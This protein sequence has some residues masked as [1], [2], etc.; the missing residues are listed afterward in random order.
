MC[1]AS[2][3]YKK[4]HLLNNY[5]VLFCVLVTPK[6]KDF[7]VLKG[8]GNNNIL[9]QHGIRQRIRYQCFEKWLS[10]I[11]NVGFINF[12]KASV[13]LPIV[14]HLEGHFWF[15]A[16]NKIKIILYKRT[17]KIFFFF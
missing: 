3:N 12:R 17:C 16:Q 14:E 6:K 15:E 4:N 11:E 1:Y 10:K 2:I 9:I 5:F 8:E 13:N 7:D